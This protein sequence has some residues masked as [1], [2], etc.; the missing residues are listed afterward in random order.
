MPF[1]N[2]YNQKKS[3]KKK[4]NPTAPSKTAIDAAKELGMD[5]GKSWNAYSKELRVH[6]Y[7]KDMKEM[8]R[9]YNK[10]LEFPVV[11]YWRNQGSEGTMIDIGGNIIELYNK[12][13]TYHKYNK[14]YYGNVSLS[15]RVPSVHKLYEKF[16]K[17]NIQVGNLEENSWGDSSFEIID[18]EGNRLIFFSPTISKE[19]YYN[20]NNTIK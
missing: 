7:V 19:K 20:I 1:L 2:N 18:L 5:L 10:F 16:S 12:N 6:I 14:N 13:G 3:V 8:V 11:H 17:K 4:K 15:L 9:F